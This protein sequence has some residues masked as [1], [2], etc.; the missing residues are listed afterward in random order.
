LNCWG[1]S[2]EVDVGGA[3]H[4]GKE[5]L[6][7]ESA[8]YRAQSFEADSL[9]VAEA[10]VQATLMPTLFLSQ[11]QSVVQLGMEDAADVPLRIH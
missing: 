4:W 8:L 9:L 2:L 10:E 5:R 1:G 6:S 11:L 7:C 3:L